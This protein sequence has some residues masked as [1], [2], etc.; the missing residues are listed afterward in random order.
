MHSVDNGAMDAVTQVGQPDGRAAA[1][2]PSLGSILEAWLSCMNVKVTHN[3]ALIGHADLVSERGI[4]PYIAMR[5][6]L[7]CNEIFGTPIPVNV[8]KS[9]DSL[10]G[11]EVDPIDIN[12]PLSAMN[13]SA[14]RLTRFVL[15]ALMVDAMNGLLGLERQGQTVK[16]EYM[17]WPGFSPAE[18]QNREIASEE[19]R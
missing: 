5:A 6:S 2:P 9:N 15:V 14:G 1:A 3:G 10:L 13:D 11:Y 12:A 17:Q 16:L 8:R 7:L 4:L 19:T 18:R